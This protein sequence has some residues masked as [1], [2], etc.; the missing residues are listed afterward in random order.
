M[1]DPLRA[2]VRKIWIR[3]NLFL[4]FAILLLHIIPFLSII[5]PFEFKGE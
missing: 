3:A 5:N 1:V 4:L 2:K